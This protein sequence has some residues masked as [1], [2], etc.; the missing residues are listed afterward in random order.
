MSID[1]HTTEKPATSLADLQQAAHNDA[2]YQSLLTAINDGFPPR[3]D[4]SCSDLRQYWMVRDRLSI[5]NGLATMDGRLI[6]PQACR[7]RILKS[8]HSAHQGTTKMMARAQQ[9]VYWPRLGLEIRNTRYNCQKCNERAPSQP[10]EPLQLTP[11][12]IYPFQSICMDFFQLGHHEYI[13]IVDR[14]SCWIAI[15]HFPNGTTSGKL[16]K[17]C[18][19]L[20]TAYGA[21]EEVSTDGGLQFTSSEFQGF[22]KDWGI[23]F[24][25]SSAEY[26]QSNGRAEASVKS[27]KKIIRDST[28]TD[29]SLNNDKAARATLQHRNTP[30]PE[31]GISPAQL[32]FHRQLRDSLPANPKHY[33]LNKQWIISASEREEAFA[34]TNQDAENR[35]NRKA[36]PLAPLNIQTV[37]RVQSKG[38]WNKSGR[39]VEVL[40]HRQYRVRLDGSGRV[41]LRNRKF[42]RPAA[43]S[44]NAT[45]P[46]IIPSAEYSTMPTL[47]PPPAQVVTDADISSSPPT[48][49]PATPAAPRTRVPRALKG[50]W[51]Y[52]EPGQAESTCG[53]QRRSPATQN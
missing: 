23:K 19:D 10:S 2:S 11:S 9:T 50:L 21:P 33:Q 29:G 40:P 22:L 36:H 41:T 18:R 45:Q 16:I 17:V 31:L 42:L 35:F 7:S 46:S 14:F 38:L 37:V 48:L 1:D 24:R 15:Y 34:K 32:L 8:L 27:A 39:I 43:T 25:L 12:P 4:K 26:P 53:Q 20:F 13:S 5:S 52:N 6:I 47:T 30:I 3:A 49:S 44:S 51:D 28:N